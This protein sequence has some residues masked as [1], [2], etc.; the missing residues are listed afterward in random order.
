MDGQTD[1]IWDLF[2]S[3]CT[4][5]GLCLFVQRRQHDLYSFSV[6]VN[7]F[8]ACVELSQVHVLTVANIR[9]QLHSTQKN[10]KSVKEATVSSRRYA[11]R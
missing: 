1:L 2:Q 10:V 11:E 8:L 4:H 5:S 6:V 3:M 7:R 9:A